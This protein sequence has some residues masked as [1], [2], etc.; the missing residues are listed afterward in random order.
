MR[1]KKEFFD[2]DLTPL[3]DVVFLLLIFFM[4]TSV[5]KKD[6]MA[7]MLNLPKGEHATEKVKAKDVDILVTRKKFAFENK[8]VKLKTLDKKLSQIKDKKKLIN[9]RIDKNVRYKRVVKVLDLL[10]KYEI[11][12][13]AL[14]NKQ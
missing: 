7:L 3:I 13:I 6:D 4:V 2:P 1:R 12:N 11:T 8:V 9:V 10:K 5:F 14:V